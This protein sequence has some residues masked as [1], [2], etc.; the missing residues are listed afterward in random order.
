MG[1]I[2]SAPLQ[3]YPKGKLHLFIHVPKELVG[4]KPTRWV[5][6]KG[7]VDKYRTRLLQWQNNK[8]GKWDMDHEKTIDRLIFRFEL[9]LDDDVPLMRLMRRIGKKLSG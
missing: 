9:V 8:T 1:E 4:E 6:P 7:D 5:M 3:K 2:C